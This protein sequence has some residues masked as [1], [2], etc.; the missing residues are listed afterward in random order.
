R[1]VTKELGGASEELLSYPNGTGAIQLRPASRPGDPLKIW[2][3][4][5]GDNRSVMAPFE[6]WF[7]HTTRL[8][9]RQRVLDALEQL[10]PAARANYA[11]PPLGQDGA[12]VWQESH[13][14]FLDQVNALKAQ[15]PPERAAQL[16]IPSIVIERSALASQ[17]V[18]TRTTLA[19]AL[20]LF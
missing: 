16:D 9:F 18:G 3:W 7:W 17:P 6:N 20:V 1:N 2:C 14:Q 19:A 11:L 10:E 5:P 12:W 13:E 15:L 4:Y 8:Y